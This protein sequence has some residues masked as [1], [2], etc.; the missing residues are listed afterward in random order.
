MV[1][2]IALILLILYT[3]HIEWC[4]KD[5]LTS[6]VRTCVHRSAQKAGRYLKLVEDSIACVWS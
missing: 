5:T 2:T 3:N 4:G 1:T 6:T